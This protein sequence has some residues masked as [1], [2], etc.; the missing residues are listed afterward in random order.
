MGRE[1]A[2]SP[3]LC[4][5]SLSSSLGGGWVGW[6]ILT[7]AKPGEDALWAGHDLDSSSGSWSLAEVL[8]VRKGTLGDRSR[9]NCPGGLTRRWMD[10]ASEGT[11]A[12][13]NATFR[14][15][16]APSSFQ[17]S[18]ALGMQLLGILSVQPR[19]Q[20]LLSQLLGRQ[21]PSLSVCSLLPRSVLH[22]HPRG[23][24]WV[25]SS[26]VPGLPCPS[27]HLW[28]QIRS[29]WGRWGL[30]D[31]TE[32]GG[33]QGGWRNYGMGAQEEEHSPSLHTCKH[34]PETGRTY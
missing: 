3:A 29:D 18:L 31:I 10:R 25:P 14:E 5:R 27:H 19:A 20:P 34:M 12:K 17:P 30:S 28:L 7:T 6:A 2:G 22:P 13:F 8:S 23:R 9:S 33:K 11:R 21:G 16:T 32:G 26:H 15:K 4:K 1:A 24:A